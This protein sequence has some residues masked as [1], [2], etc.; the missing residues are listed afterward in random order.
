MFCIVQLQ[1]ELN[2][3]RKKV[4]ELRESRALEQRR[5]QQRLKHMDD[6]INELKKQLSISQVHIEVLHIMNTVDRYGHF[7]YRN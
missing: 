6:E 7:L 5:I 1:K 3:E 2:F 4:T